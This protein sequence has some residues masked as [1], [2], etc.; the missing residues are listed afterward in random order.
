MLSGVRW[1]RPRPLRWSML[2]LLLLLPLLPLARP[3]VTLRRE[4][5]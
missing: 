3:V 1:D 2:L 5:R 4:S